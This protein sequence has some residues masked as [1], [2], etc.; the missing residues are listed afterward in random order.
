MTCVRKMSRTNPLI[1]EKFTSTV[2]YFQSHNNWG[3]IFTLR[4]AFSAWYWQI[5]W[6]EMGSI[7]F[8]KKRFNFLS[9]LIW[10]RLSD[11]MKT[12]NFLIPTLD[13]TNE[14]NLLVKSRS[15]STEYHDRTMRKRSDY[16]ERHLHHYILL[17]LDHYHR[18]SCR[19]D[20]T[21]NNYSSYRKISEKWIHLCTFSIKDKSPSYAELVGS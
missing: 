13:E 11:N 9:K 3:K 10:K 20:E 17:R 14:M 8:S 5:S 12:I 7:I 6:T 15:N 21:W 1:S 18:K 4:S 16:S 2:F 19:L